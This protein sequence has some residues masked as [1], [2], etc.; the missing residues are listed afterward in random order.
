MTEGQLVALIIA[1]ASGLVGF[2][3]WAVLR[4]TKSLDDN[5]L[6]NR[7]DAAAKVQLAREM[8]VL[9]TKID[10]I[11]RWVEEH[12]PV[13]QPIPRAPTQRPRTNPGEYLH[14]REKP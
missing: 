10:G 11:G 2:A 1:G 6:S 14:V 4:I 13:N 3:R 8:A 5:S 9:S 12:T 7:E